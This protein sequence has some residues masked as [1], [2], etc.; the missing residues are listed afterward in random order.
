MSNFELAALLLLQ[1]TVILAACR[2]LGAAVRFA[3][4]P[5][6]VGEIIAG[7]ALGPSLLGW[8]N[9]AWH[10]A[11]FPRESLAVL[12]AVAQLGLALYMFLVGLEFRADLVSRQ[13][14]S[15]ASVSIAGI[16]APF[17]LGGIIALTLADD[18][19]LFN[20]QVTPAEA[21]LYLGAAMSITAFPMLARIIEE[22]G[23]SGTRLGALA[24]AAGAVSDVVA[25][26]VLAGV[27][28]S[29]ADDANI[30]LW[31]VGGGALYTAAVL[32]GLRPALARFAADQAR[33]GLA[34]TLMLVTFC[35]WLTDSI[36]IHAVFGSFI[37]GVAMPRGEFALDVQR[38]VGPLTGALLLP[39]YFAYSGLNTRINLVNT[40]Q[41][42]GLALLILAAAT[43]GKG[44]ACFLAA[45]LNREPT[46]DAIAIGALMNA[47]GLMELVILNI[48]YERGLITQRLFSIMVL[49]AIV[50][51]LMAT[52][53][54]EAAYGRRPGP[55]P[56]PQA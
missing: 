54:F 46:R 4:Q 6:V 18:A 32:L 51:T 47:R 20:E 22:R 27:L 41:L 37:L 13:W 36:G 16:V 48:G 17:T 31:A 5:P 49:M 24:L 12:Y 26:C 3:G 10:Q 38:R 44:A 2:I 35:A 8:A 9:P 25:W 11:L 1:L 45:K 55:R 28:A 15:A 39:V 52:P 34:L 43:V 14:R 21:V 56:T 50:T 29:F 23:L 19:G 53:I 7:I 30:A 42:W 40:P 33:S